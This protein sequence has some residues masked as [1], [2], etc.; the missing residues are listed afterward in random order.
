MPINRR[1]YKRIKLEAD[2]T[3]QIIDQKGSPVG[4]ALYGCLQDISVG[5]ACFTIQCSKKAVGLT[6]LARMTTLTILFE[7]GLHIK[8]NGLILGAVFDLLGSYTIHLHF[9]QQF[10]K[11][12][13]KK[14]IDICQ[15]LKSPGGS[16][17]L[18]KDELALVQQ[19]LAKKKQSPK[20]L[21]EVKEQRKSVEIIALTRAIKENPRDVKLMQKLANLYISYELYEEAIKPFKAAI[22]LNPKVAELQ[23]LLGNTYYKAQQFQESLAPLSLAVRLNPKFAKAHYNLCVVNELVGNEEAAQKHFQIAI[24]LDPDIESKV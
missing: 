2:I 24:K 16:E 5:G 15:K 11:E 18:Q 22:K 14:F 3:A 9:S 10:S 12:S 13:F 7:K 6:L 1:Q 17:A 4:S 21:G 8:V 20:V 23:Y 19:E